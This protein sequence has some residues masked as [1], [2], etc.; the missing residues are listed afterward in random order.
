MAN[1]KYEYVKSFEANDEVMFP[2]LIVVRIDGRDFR[3]FSEVH[4]FERPNDEKALNL[5][6]ACAIS[7]LEEYPDIVFSYGFSDE[8]SFVFKKTTKFYQ[9]R[10]SK[11][12]SLI[13]SFFSSIYATKWKEFFP[14]KDMRYPP[15]FNG[16]VICCA[17]IEVLQEYLAWRQNDC[18]ANN[19]YNTCLWKLVESGKTEKEAQEILKGTQ[20]QEKNEL[21]FQEFGVNYKKLPEMF[22]QGSCVFMTQEEDIAK[23]SENGTPVKRLRRKARI[24][25]S[26]NIAGRSFW[27]V[28]QNLLKQLGCFAED[29][30][31]INPDYIRSFLFENKLMPSTWI[32]IRI[33]GCHFHR[34]CDVHAFEK[35]N[36]VQALNLMN[37]C[38]VAVL[39]EFQDVIFSYGVSDEYSFVLKK[40][41]KF[42]QRQARKNSSI[43]PPLMEGL[44]AIHHLRFFEIILLGDKL[45]IAGH[46]NNQYNT[47]FWALVKSGKSKSDAQNTL[48]GTQALEKNQILAQF[49]IDYNALPAILRQGSSVFSVKE[50]VV[51]HEYGSSVEKL[52]NKVIVEYCNIIEQSFW[53]AHPGILD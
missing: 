44:Y 31:K 6:N 9:R 10:A 13:V 14:M 28:H 24:L 22:R 53:E 43:L 36:D 49:G 21:L 32:V 39:E 47:C 8:Y 20:K 15:T 26:E 16:R 46:I 19:Q 3:R 29:I 5:M 40:D 23:Y 11:I 51:I 41:S 18:H 42:L 4:E 30:G 27:N 52:R 34:F 1:S 50:D 17:T 7:V 35:P 48:K 12:L 2:N 25:H 33:D 37:S 38:A 45:I